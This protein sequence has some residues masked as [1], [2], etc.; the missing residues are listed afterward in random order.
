MALTIKLTDQ[1]I[2]ACVYRGKFNDFLNKLKEHE[3]FNSVVNIPKNKRNDGTREE[4]ILRFFAYYYNRNNFKHSVVQFLNEYMGHAI[5]EF[6]FDEAETLFNETFAQLRQELPKGIK[7]GQKGS[8]P[9]NLYEAISVGAAD[10][11]IAGNDIF[12]KGLADWI[13]DDALTKLT[14][15]ATNSRPRLNAR[16]DYC[17]GRFQA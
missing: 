10:T 7:R 15:G 1:E 9:A 14:T 11:I 12:N 6:N 4:W 8:T 17:S 16:I 3:A 2:R 13:E 5:T